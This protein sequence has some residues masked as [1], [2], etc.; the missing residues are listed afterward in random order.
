MENMSDNYHA[1]YVHAS[2]FGVRAEIGNN[3]AANVY[4]TAPNPRERTRIERSFAHG[5]GLLDYQG[6]RLVVTDP[7]RYPEYFAALAER[8]GEEY[9]RELANTDIHLMVYPNLILHTNYCHYR[10]VHPL[11]VNHTEINT[12]PCKLVGAPDEVNQALVGA[13]SMHV[14]PAGRVQVDDLE[15]FARVQKG[16][17][18]EAAEWV[19]FKMRGLNEHVNEH[20]ELECEFLSEM[21]PRGYYREWLR[22]MT[23]GS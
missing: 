16:L 9:A 20:G 2:A 12:F 7:E 21:I 4:G 8:H 11:A 19:L 14:S 3:G 5:H 1:V 6:G 23:Q 18:V 17:A 15:A 10:V 13:S 22:L